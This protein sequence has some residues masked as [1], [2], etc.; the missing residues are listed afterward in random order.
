MGITHNFELSSKTIDDAEIAPSIF[1]NGGSNEFYSF[2]KTNRYI[3]QSTGK[4]GFLKHHGQRRKNRNGTV[5]T[6]TITD[7]VTNNFTLNNVEV[8]LYSS[9][10]KGH[11]EIVPDASL[12]IPLNA[13]NTFDGYWQLKLDYNF[14]K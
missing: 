5:T 12:Y 1:I 3:T 13:N 14:G 2:L 10:A 9:F 4:N 6:S 11:F 8:N 7:P